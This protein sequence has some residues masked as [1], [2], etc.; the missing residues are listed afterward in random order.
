MTNEPPKE[1]EKE[2]ADPVNRPA[3]KPKKMFVPKKVVVK[4][5]K[6]QEYRVRHIRVTS[7]ESA[8]L[9]RQTLLDFQKELSDQPSDD[10]DKV[11][12]DRKKLENLFI[13]I[14]KKYSTCP[15]RILGGDLDWVYKGM[16]FNDEVLAENLIE[17]IEQ[18]EKHVLP[19][20]IKTKLGFHII[21]VCESRVLTKQKEEKEELDPRYQALHEQP[22]T[23]Q[24]ID[25][26]IPT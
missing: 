20:P 13:R 23:V 26:N 4:S 2:S 14:A 25:K 7:L 12:E 19:E 8:N 1:P 24:K 22:K 10:P 9:F 11:F 5:T 21:L 15:T 16:T 17:R 3:I 6:P 18:T